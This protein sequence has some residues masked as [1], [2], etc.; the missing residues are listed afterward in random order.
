LVYIICSIKYRTYHGISIMTVPQK[1]SMAAM[2][3]I[4]LAAIA[5]GNN[6]GNSMVAVAVVAAALTKTLAAIAMAGL[7]GN[8]QPKA[9]E[10]E[11]ARTMMTIGKDGNNNGQGGRKWQ[12]QR[13]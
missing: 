1:L 8:N 5:V 12:G 11:M 4:V 3:A 13:Q 6:G 9:A 7:T 2:A 10:E